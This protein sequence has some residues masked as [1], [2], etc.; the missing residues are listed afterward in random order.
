M[1]TS[2]PE[3]RSGGIDS[4]RIAR[5]VIEA[6]VFVVLPCCLLLV[7]A[8]FA[9][10]ATYASDFHPFWQAAGDVVHGRNPYTHP[11]S[12]NSLG[13]PESRYIYPPAVADLL[14][15]LAPLPFLAAAIVFLLVSTAAIPLS[16]WLLGVRDW[17][18]YGM[19][20]LWI[21]I[22]HG[23]RLGALTPLLILGIA[24][25]WRYR[26][27]AVASSL[28]SAP[29]V[30]TKIFMWPLLVWQAER[31]TPRMIRSIA[32]SLV[33]FT[34]LP[35]ATIGFKGLV[36]YPKLL[37]NEASFWDRGYSLSALG[38]TIGLPGTASRLAAT[39]L[40]L[41]ACAALV[42]ARRRAL[43]DDREAL[44][45]AIGI[46]IVFSPVSWLHYSALLLVAAALLS[47]RLS[48]A[49]LLPLGFWISPF[50]EADGTVWRILFVLA[51]D[52]VTLAI[53][54]RVYRS[55]PERS[56][57]TTTSPRAALRLQQ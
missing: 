46:A 50:E 39:A 52:V 13:T 36:G 30:V 17:R 11:V 44:A 27:S 29:V 32:A 16:L 5:G 41:L 3:G 26:D 15:P 25:C 24:T 43:I 4:D 31:G 56:T 8:F 21:P 19:A 20:F 47:P 28:A 45:L 10:R 57:T 51:L 7:I 38:T 12:F 18:C 37:N 2:V 42:L 40:A 54:I 23:I 49:W 22:D 48:A 6:L 33:G 1:A 53:L 34:L 35:W 14:V 9:P 55:A